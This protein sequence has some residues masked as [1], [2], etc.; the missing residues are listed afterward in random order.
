M[1]CNRC[2]EDNSRSARFCRKCGI[3]LGE[4]CR[5]CGFENPAESTFCGGCGARLP[6]VSAEDTGGERRQLTV[7]FCDLVGATELSHSMDPED[8]RKM[9]A[10]Y[11]RV[12]GDAVGAHEGHVAQYLGDGVVV[13]FGYPRA[14]EDEAHRAVRCGLDIIE[15]VRRLAQDAAGSEGRLFDVRLGA[16]TGRV[17]VGPVGAGDRQSRIA[18]GE[19]P[20]LAAR[21]QAEAPVGS[22][23]VSDTTW[24]IVDGYFTGT[25]LGERVLKGVPNP[26]S[27]WMVTGEGGSRE[28]VEV[29][30]RLTPLVGRR[31]ER[32]K[33]LD[34][35]ADVQSGR[36]HF[37]HL[38]G[39]PGMGKSR[40]AQW[41]CEEIDDANTELL[42]IRATPYNSAS[43]FYPIIELIQ[44]RF[45]I[46]PTLPDDERL[47]RLEE[48]LAARGN[49]DSDAVL[50]LCPLLSIST[51]GRFAPLTLSPARRRT[52]T[53][54]LLIELALR[55]ARA[56]P[57]LLLV[58]DLHWADPSTVELFE[59]LVRRAPDLP[60]L[61]VF[62]ARPEFEAAW[63]SSKAVGLLELSKFDR[64]DSES[65]VRSVASGKQLPSEVLRQIVSRSD[66]VPLFV[67]EMTRFVLDSGLLEERTAAWVA[68]GEIPAEA[69]PVSMDASLTARIDRLGASRATAQLAGTIGRE[70]GWALLKEV[71]DRD[72][73]TLQR[74]LQR[75]MRSGLVWQTDAD[76]ETYSFKHALVRDAAYNS[77]LRSVR[78]TYHNRIA[79][80][81]LE[82]FPEQAVLRPD[83]IADHLSSAGRDD[84]AV[85]FYEAAGRQALERA[86]LHEAA[87]HFRRAIQC[88]GTGPTPEAKEHELDF[89]IQLAPLLMAVYGWGS[90]EVEDACGR[91]LSLAAELGRHDLSYAPMWGQWTVRFLRGEMVTAMAAAESVLQMAKASGVPMLELTGRHATSYTSLYRGEF[92]QALSEA[93]AGL[94]LYGFEQEK[95]LAST[96]SLSSSV[97]LMASRATALWMLGRPVEAEEEWDRMLGLGRAL[98][99]PPSLA[100]ALAFALHGGGIRYSY[101]GAMAELQ[102][103]AEELMSLSKEEDFFLWYAV[104]YTYRGIVAQSLG[105]RDEALVQMEEGLELFEQTGSRLTLVMMN[106]LCAEAMYRLGEGDR[107]LEKLHV[108][109][110]EMRHRDEGLLAPDIWRIRGSILVSSG[111]DA[112][113]EAAYREAIHRARHQ[114]ALALQ[115]RTALDL[116][117]LRE[118]QGRSDQAREL[119]AGILGGFSQGLDRPEPARAVGIAG[120]VST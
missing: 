54:E 73:V 6:E 112:A 101:V 95:V 22:L 114:G 55:L 44:R 10:E 76:S 100:A 62:T 52:Q 7:L 90:H 87:D 120:G 38:S 14:H 61:C 30:S 85:A 111:D 19:T 53:M 64:S 63:T 81:L 58:E 27:L 78:Q 41:F 68:V 91:A 71:S 116:H 70:F 13:Y 93:D 20:N 24:G 69:I 31:E 106:V 66:G 3:Q 84:A 80:T 5:A 102:A 60:L 1:I 39:E 16:H 25:P 115:L 35:W 107:A 86:S 36:S 88:L 108:A 29:A 26:M 96:F 18:V 46:H 50:L 105:Y 110:T 97:C 43:A 2:A 34:V 59:H 15:G 23:V 92:E 79:T 94:A 11:Q 109:E 47:R 49:V 74:D 9:L 37:L 67:E 104:G 21:I 99:H 48:A 12:C 72:E 103:V 17:V 57:T 45:G 4:S 40:L 8:L 33:L 82:R 65:V 28:R 83:L 77:L 42:L 51:E 98:Q 119:L 117:D 32:K 89:L 75:L 118:R 113:G 56:G